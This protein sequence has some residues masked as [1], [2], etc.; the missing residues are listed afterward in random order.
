MRRTILTF[1]LLSTIL[2]TL[3]AQ[4]EQKN[5]KYKEFLQKF[6]QTELPF[7]YKKKLSKIKHRNKPL[8]NISFENAKKYLGLKEDELFVKRLIYNNETFEKSYVEEKNLP[9][10]HLHFKATNY[11][12]IIYRHQLGIKSDTVYVY[13]RLFSKKG[14]FLDEKIIGEHFTREN[15]WI[16]SVFL[17]NSHFKI[18]KYRI[19][20]KN[21][22]VVNNIYHVKN[23]KK[24]KT[25]LKIENYQIDEQGNIHKTK[26]S[27]KK[28]LKKEVSYYKS[29]NPQSNDPMNKF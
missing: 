21:Y 26:K 27:Q 25:L 14:H 2:G 24:P 10:A 29:Y 11:D 4:I 17:S 28:Y 19:N 22:K 1:V 5:E 20:H 13:L 6:I 3:N 18:F 9:A 12:G 15:D 16:S 8:E 7:N 23:E